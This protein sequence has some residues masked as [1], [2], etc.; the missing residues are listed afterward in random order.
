M[1]KPRTRLVRGY[2]VGV[3]LRG[4][5]SS[6]RVKIVSYFQQFII[7]DVLAV[8]AE[9]VANVCG[10]GHVFF[11]KVLGHVHERLARASVTH[12]TVRVLNK[13]GG[14]TGRLKHCDEFTLYRSTVCLPLSEIHNLSLPFGYTIG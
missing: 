7:L 13:R 11:S 5:R 14:A 9:S 2:K 6:L 10:D 12:D 1:K 4:A 3:W 8:D